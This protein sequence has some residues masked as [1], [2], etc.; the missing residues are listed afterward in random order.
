MKLEKKGLL[1]RF[2]KGVRENALTSPKSTKKGIYYGFTSAVVGAIGTAL[3]AK[4]P[5]IGVLITDNI[6]EISSGILAI[7]ALIVERFA[8]KKDSK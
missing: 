6:V 2:F 4:H 1:K 3:L 8:A 7:S 5:T